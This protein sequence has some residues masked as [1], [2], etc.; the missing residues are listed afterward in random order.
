M[1]FSKIGMGD[2]T[3]CLYKFIYDENDSVD[4]N[5]IQYFIMHL[6]VLRIKHIWELPVIH[7]HKIM[8]IYPY[9]F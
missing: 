1:N 6:L 3:T 8:V 9:H 5:M 2:P 7:C 4:T